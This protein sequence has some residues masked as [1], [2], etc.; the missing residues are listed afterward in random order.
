MSQKEFQNTLYTNDNLFVL[1]GL[2]S[3]SVDLIYLDPPFKSDRVYSAPIGSKAA[4]VSFNDM[5]TWQDVNEA[6]LD[7]L[8]EKYPVLTKYIADVGKIHSKAMAAYL[9][10]MAQ[11]LIEMYR[12]LKNTGSLYLHCDPTAC[13][14]LKVLLDEIFDG[15]NFRNE[16]IWERATDTGSSKAIANQFPVNTDV[17]L[18]YS[19][20]DDYVFNKQYDKYSEEYVS[21]KFNNNDNDGK[22]AYRWQVLKT[23]SQETF[24]KLKVENR[25]KKTDTSKYYYFKQYLAESKGVRISNLWDAEDIVPLSPSAKES[26]GYP[27]QKPLALIHRIIKASSNEGD[28]VLDPFCGCATTCVAAQQLG[29]KW[30]GIDIEKKAVDILIERLSDDA[31]LFNDFINTT[32]IPQRTDVK[33]ETPSKSIKEQLYKKQNGM[34]NACGMEFDIWNL[35]IDHIIPKTKGGGDYYENYQL[36]CS[37]CNKI[38]GDRPMEYLR[39]KIET[40]ERMM[41]NKIIF[42]E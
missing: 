23:Y 27:T 32:L 3:E 22:G 24:D 16:I 37:S 38:K 34:C 28:I 39:M 13:H 2:N 21:N 10:Y 9:T 29:R 26:K 31:G 12:I 30:I 41:K 1:K 17:I 33:I 18:F 4:G 25:L 20:S 35:E 19:K 5:W 15:R 6:Y 7:T 11:R 36:L 42:G 8:A 14:Y 40:R